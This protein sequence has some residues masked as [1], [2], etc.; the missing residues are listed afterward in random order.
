M[1]GRYVLAAQ[2][3]LAL[4]DLLHVVE[5]LQEHDPGEHRQAVEVAVQPLVLAHD[6]ARGLD[7]AAELLG[8]GQGLRSLLGLAIM[9]FRPGHLSVSS[10]LC[11][12]Q[13]RLQLVHGVAQLVGAAEQLGDLD[14][15]A[16]LGDRRHLQA[17]R[18]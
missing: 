5:E 12:V 6:V 18:A 13:Q 1:A 10:S 8:G 11:R 14:H 7:Q 9:R 15:V 16:V 17:R 3:G 4:L 2:L